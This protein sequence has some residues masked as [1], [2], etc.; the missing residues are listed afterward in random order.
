MVNLAE[1]IR[2]ILKR[3][4][5]NTN[6]NKNKN[7]NYHGQSKTIIN[8]DVRNENNSKHANE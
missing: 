8:I 3:S 6:K 1:K 7:N 5:S 2:I 4:D